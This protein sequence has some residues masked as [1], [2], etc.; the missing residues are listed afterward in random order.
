MQV[1]EEYDLIVI[2]NQL[3]GYLLATAAAQKGK[4][5]LLIEVK[6][7]ESAV[8]G[9]PSG[10]FLTDLQWE[11]ILG[12]EQNSA[13]DRFLRDLGVYQSIDDLFPRFSPALQF[14]SLNERLDLESAANLPM[15]EPALFG[16]LSPERPS[17]KLRSFYSDSFAHG[18]RYSVGGKDSLKE[19]LTARL[20]WYGGR[21]KRD[22]LVEEIIFERGRL[23]GALLSSFEGFVR[24]PMIVGNTHAASFLELIPERL[25]PEAL[26]REVASMEPRFWRF[27]FSVKLPD[28]A[29]PE[30]MGN[31]ICFQELEGS[32]EEG[33]MLQVF[34]LPNGAYSGIRSGERVL[35]VRVLLPLTPR[36]IRPEFLAATVKRCLYRLESFIPFIDVDASVITPDPSGIGRDWL[37]RN[38]YQFNSI[39]D[40]PRDIIVYSRT[41]DSYGLRGVTSDWSRFGLN[42]LV[43]ASRDVAPSLGV[44]GDLETSMQLAGRIATVQ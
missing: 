25:R 16:S 18:L 12:L 36:C 2:G 31:H 6:A 5:V 19:I 43:L 23:T 1:N 22:A 40:I 26:K 9:R 35:L 42:G 10:D 3:G 41:P 32:P 17:D 13:Q 33:Q 28:H 21:V 44:M 27:N 8:F 7:R 29:I 15:L 20:K 24:S 14:L 11:P 38:Y 34:V 4:N 30:G 39:A 37:F